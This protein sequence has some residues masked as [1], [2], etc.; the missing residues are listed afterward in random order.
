ML[1]RSDYET[2]LRV[3]V[4]VVRFL[5]HQGLAFR[6]HD[7]SSTSRNKGNF[8]ELL[9]WYGARC[10]EVADVINENAPGNC[11]LTSHEIQQDITQACA[12]ETTEII[13]SELGNAGFSL[14]VDESRDVSVKEQ[15]VVILRLVM[16]FAK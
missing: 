12:E 3:V 8:L 1:F 7:E 2:R 6:G 10:K 5:I 15:M 16:C 13:M 4:G 9:E 11:Q 14:L